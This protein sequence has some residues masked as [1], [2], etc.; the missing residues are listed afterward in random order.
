MFSDL[1]YTDKIRIFS[2]SF[3]VIS[4]LIIIIL[5][6]FI[7][8]NKG[9]KFF[10][11]GFFND[12]ILYNF[13][14]S[15]VLGVL[16]SYIIQFIDNV[17][18]LSEYRIMSHFPIWVQLVF[19]V[20]T[21]DFYIYWFH[22]WQHKNKVLWRIHEAHHSTKS[23]DWLSGVR[24][25]SLEILINQTI[26]FAPIVLLGASPEVAVYKGAVSAVWGMYIHSNIDV[27]SGWLQYIINGPEMHRWHHSNEEDTDHM[28]KN[29]STKLAIWDWLFGTA[30][31]PA[32]KSSVYGI[33]DPDY[34]AGYLKQHLYAF[35]KFRKG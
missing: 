9:Q 29:F 18:T 35:R 1:D 33:S 13:L 6:R 8:Y 3:V 31:R 27:R 17:T 28:N 30:Y 4:A 22:R 25:H 7:P 14:Q 32:K 5:E 34:P 26:E 20:I 10:R 23:V 19:F 24:S 12:F 21:H 11:E 16:I 2:F 15:F